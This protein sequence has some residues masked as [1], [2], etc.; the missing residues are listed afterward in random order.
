[1]CVGVKCHKWDELSILIHNEYLHTA[2][3]DAEYLQNSPRN[4]RGVILHS[5]ASAQGRTGHGG[6]QSKFATTRVM[7][8]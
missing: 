7:R 3:H 6:Q 2:P 8:P 4:I 1:M 5:D